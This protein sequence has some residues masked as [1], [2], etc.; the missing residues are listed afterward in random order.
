MNSNG[1]GRSGQVG[2]GE[3]GFTL[4]E[5]LVAVM[6]LAI[7]LLGVVGAATLQ[8]G[9]IALSLPIGQAAITRGYHVTTAAML[10]QESLEQVKRLQW[11]LGPP[12]VDQF[13]PLDANGSPPGFADEG[14]GAIAGYPNFSRQVRVTDDSPV[15]NMKTVT[16]TVRFN[17][18]YESGMRQ[19][20]IAVSTLIAALP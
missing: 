6:I 20:S 8:S 10:A 15:T 3:G 14:L 16:V 2:W 18:P 9:G 19:E 4:V 13:A 5:V 7:A 11:T 17:L 12:E 1:Q